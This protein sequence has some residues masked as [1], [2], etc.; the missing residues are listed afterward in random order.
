M[1]K[2]IFFARELR[3][4]QTE[5]EKILWFQLRGRKLAGIKFK[6]QELIK[7]YIV[8]FVSYEKMLIIELD[9]GQHTDPNHMTKDNIRTKFLE[10]LGFKVVRF[11]DNDVYNN[12]EGVLEVILSKAST[13]P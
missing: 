6:R 5:V 3:K 4:N 2:K 1:D 11:W 8:D 7:P 13:S 10:K 9:G 12:I